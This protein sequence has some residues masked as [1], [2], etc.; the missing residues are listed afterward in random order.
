M[1]TSLDKARAD[2][3][4][5]DE[6]V[7]ITQVLNDLQGQVLKNGVIATELPGT[8]AYIDAANKGVTV[9]STEN[10]KKNR[11][12]LGWSKDKE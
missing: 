1:P 9:K 6:L 5:V 7:A 3:L 4:P 10:P 11:D 12:R 8:R 2:G